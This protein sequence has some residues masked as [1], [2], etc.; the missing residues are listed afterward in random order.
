[1]DNIIKKVLSVAILTTFTLLESGCTPAETSSDAF[2]TEETHE[3]RVYTTEV[4]PPGNNDGVVFK[5]ILGETLVGIDKF[6]TLGSDFYIFNDW[7]YISL[8]DGISQNSYDN[9][10]NFD[11]YGE[12]EDF[13]VQENDFFKMN[14]G[15]ETGGLVLK[16]GYTVYCCTPDASYTE[17]DVLSAAFSG[18]LT[19]SGY[20]YTGGEDDGYITEGTIVFLVDDG[21]WGGLPYIARNNSSSFGM[22][23]DFT[24]LAHAPILL[25][26][27]DENQNF[28]FPKPGSIIHVSA[29][30]ADPRLFMDFSGALGYNPNTATLIDFTTID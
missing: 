9:P 4:L 11:E 29:T 18:E 13:P 2:Y 28:D 17:L 7:T 19:I 16:E 22:F 26:D 25:L 8:S 3:N 23:G 30:I 20:I 5:G 27:Y 21:E 15:D 6:L 24:W 10:E 1:M 14:E 12:Y